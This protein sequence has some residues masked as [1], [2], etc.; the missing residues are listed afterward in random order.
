M[1]DYILT[2][3]IYIQDPGLT[4]FS[5]IQYKVNLRSY[6]Y[7]LTIFSEIQHKSIYMLINST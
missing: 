2:N 7:I 3:S 4:I 6:I 5:E 1:I